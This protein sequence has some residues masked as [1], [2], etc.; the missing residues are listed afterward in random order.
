MRIR[1]RIQRKR[2]YRS[3]FLA[4]GVRSG[5]LWYC[6]LESM[7][8]EGFCGVLGGIERAGVSD[9]VVW[10]GAL[11]HRDERVGRIGVPLIP[12]PAYSPERNPAERLFE[13]IRAEIEG[14]VYDDLDAK[15]AGVD[16]LLAAWDAAPTESAPSPAGPGSSTHSDNCPRQARPNQVRGYHSPDVPTPRRVQRPRLLH[17][18]RSPLSI[19]RQRSVW[20]LERSRRL[21]ASPPCCATLRRTSSGTRASPAGSR[22]VPPG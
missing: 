4:V 3:L 8:G 10:D 11:G 14:K 7:Q 13:A 2:R 5:R 18:G 20:S 22:L 6:W 19:S 15:C 17:T 1:Q 21:R 12:L 9:A 16:A